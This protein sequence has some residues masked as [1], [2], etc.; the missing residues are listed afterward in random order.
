MKIMIF[1]DTASG[2]STFAKKLGTKLGIPS[3]SLDQVMDTVGRDRRKDITDKIAQITKQPDWI[4]EGN[5][6]TKDKEARIKAA[7]KVIVFKSSPWVTFLRHLVRHIKVYL[8][9]ESR[10][11]S[12]DPRLNLKYFIP[13]I[14]VKFSPRRESAFA[15]VK[16][17]RKEITVIHN[18]E[19]ANS[20]LDKTNP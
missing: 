12:D 11:G 2:K 19:E 15:L 14:F 16:S 9:I 8:G 3:I 7:D 1:G 5:A 18:H 13:Y 4:L 20:Y 10:A 17:M 6:F